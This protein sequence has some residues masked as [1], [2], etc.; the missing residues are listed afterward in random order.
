MGRHKP[1][2][3][4]PYRSEHKDLLLRVLQV[5]TPI[6]QSLQTLAR[7]SCNPP[8]LSSTVVYIFVSFLMRQRQMFIFGPLHAE[9]FTCLPA[10]ACLAA[11][12][13][14]GVLELRVSELGA[15][16]GDGRHG[17]AA[18]RLF[19]FF[20]NA[21]FSSVTESAALSAAARS[22]D[23]VDLFFAGPKNIVKLR[24]IRL[25]YLRGPNGTEELLK[26]GGYVNA[27]Q[28]D[29][30]GHRRCVH[31]AYD[32]FVL[33]ISKFSCLFTSLFKQFLVVLIFTL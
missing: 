28:I 10:L 27:A 6:S 2:L 18:E 24:L 25:A 19:Q 13:H 1:S 15:Q 26:L 33:P 16:G 31:R 14:L 29:P 11:L 30:V 32:G 12:L 20:I 22:N 21:S 7:M 17:A 23:L 3:L 4:R 5:P 8:K 9:G